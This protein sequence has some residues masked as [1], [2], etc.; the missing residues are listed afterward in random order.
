MLQSIIL[1]IMNVQIFYAV[2]Q[3]FSNHFG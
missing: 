3:F 2:S 1:T